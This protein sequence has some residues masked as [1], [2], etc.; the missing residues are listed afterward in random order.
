VAENNSKS[1]FF[2]SI[3]T[4]VNRESPTFDTYGAAVSH[5]FKPGAK[6]T[7]S[8]STF[9]ESRCCPKPNTEKQQTRTNKLPIW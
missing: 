8:T 7:H 1:T 4:I 6:V 9:E 3:L 2:G 5:Q